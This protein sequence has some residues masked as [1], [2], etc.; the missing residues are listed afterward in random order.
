MGAREATLKV[1][2]DTNILISALLFRGELSRIV[3]LWRDGRIVPVVSKDTFQE[4]RAVLTYPKFRLSFAEINA[5]VEEEI[6]PFFDVVE[7]PEDVKG[8]C[9]DPDDDKFIACA[10]AASADFIVSGDRSLRDVGT[11]G[12]IRIIGASEFLAMMK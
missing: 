10:S 2:L 8:I 7:V 3:D 12:S 9:A 6:L 11:C 4:L 1:V 5:L